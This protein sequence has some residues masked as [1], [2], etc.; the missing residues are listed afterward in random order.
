MILCPIG[1]TSIAIK[2]FTLT[3]ELKWYLNVTLTYRTFHLIESYAIYEF[4]QNSHI[5]D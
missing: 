3:I 5:I 1:N 2:E 4:L